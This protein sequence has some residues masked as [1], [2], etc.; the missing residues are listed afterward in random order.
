MTAARVVVVGSI[1]VDLFADV[2]R[3]PARGETVLASA[4]Y[5][6]PG[7]KGANQAVAAARWGASVSLIGAVG[8]DA[9]GDAARAALLGARVDTSLVSTV[10]ESATG[11]ALIVVEGGGENTI[12]VVSGANAALT[13]AVITA[14][15][16]AEQRIAEA[17][18][19]VLQLEIPVATALAA[20][21]SARA[22][23]VRVVL[24]ASPLQASPLQDGPGATLVRLLTLTDVLIVN[25]TEAARLD[26][27]GADATERAAR[28]RGLG[29]A[30]VVVTLGAAGSVTAD[31]DGIH[32]TPAVR[33]D[34]V[35]ATGAGDTFCGV[36][37]AELAARVPLGGG[38][39]HA[40][41]AAAL[42]T[43]RV[44]AQTA[45]PSRAAALALLADASA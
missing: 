23:G 3:L 30:V 7:G 36:L 38:L 45:M 25:E 22:A 4:S 44:G 31:G 20:A 35:D 37:A 34:P 14:G 29:P 1:N 40:S 19:V 13:P 42:A 2:E 21:Q 41:A 12:T 6:R 10:A 9:F 18:T 24:N 8:E 16:A 27:E 28:L 26:P 15:D 39:R 17:D 11:L 5:Q 32:R 43:T 33:I